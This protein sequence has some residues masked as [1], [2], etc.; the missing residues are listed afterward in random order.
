MIC[1]VCIANAAVMV[2]TATSGGGVVATVISR[3]CKLTDFR[4]LSP[5]VKAKEKQS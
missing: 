1:P 3:A 5:A 4:K 2:A